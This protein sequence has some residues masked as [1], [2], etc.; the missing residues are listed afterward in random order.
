M[1]RWLVKNVN[2]HFPDTLEECIAARLRQHGFC[3]SSVSGRWGG[4]ISLYNKGKSSDRYEIIFNRGNSG[5]SAVLPW[6][7]GDGVLKHI[8]LPSQNES[9][10][11]DALAVENSIIQ[12]LD[13]HNIFVIDGIIYNLD[14][15]VIGWQRYK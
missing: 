2:K 10:A 9:N 1:L 8:E 11:Y 6:H 5:W 3:A 13:E 7:Q 15:L 4:S 12:F 14:K